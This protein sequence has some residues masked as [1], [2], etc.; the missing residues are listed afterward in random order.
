MRII[1]IT[2]LSV[3]T[4]VVSCSK[5]KAPDPNIECN[6]EI[7]LAND[8]RPILDQHCMSCHFEGNSTGYDLHDYES[9]KSNINKVLSSL[10]ANGNDLMPQGGP[11]LA[12][13][14]IQKFECWN[15]QGKLNN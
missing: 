15:I 7:S 11:A 12:D 13:S 9:V 8:V 4:L 2:F 3:V 1:L 10:R 5:D 14:L 6:S